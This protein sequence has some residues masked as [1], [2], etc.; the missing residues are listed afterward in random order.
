MASGWTRC[1]GG[2]AAPKFTKF[3]LVR[4]LRAIADDHAARG[5]KIDG[6]TERAPGIA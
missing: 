1:T 2:D 5:R 4:V 6:E 3:T